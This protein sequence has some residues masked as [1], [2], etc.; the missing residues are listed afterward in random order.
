MS[1][2]DKTLLAGT[3]KEGWFITGTLSSVRKDYIEWLKNLRDDASSGKDRSQSV[4]NIEN[5]MRLL[6][7]A[8]SDALSSPEKFINADK[9]WSSFSSH[10]HLMFIHNKLP[11][12]SQDS[13]IEY[14]VTD[15][16][17][18]PLNESFGPAKLLYHCY[19]D[20]ENNL[21]FK[22]LHSTG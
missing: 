3:S 20:K 21:I 18:R 13:D 14:W 16:E 1:E 11:I 5:R 6:Q 2:T 15:L 8:Y 9:F 10:M 19:Y 22:N 7:T 17:M 12:K 4:D